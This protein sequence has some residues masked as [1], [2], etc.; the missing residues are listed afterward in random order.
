MTTFTPSA[1]KKAGET[2]DQAAKEMYKDAHQVIV[3]RPLTTRTSSP[4]EA[5]AVAGDALCNV[6]WHKLIA[7]AT[8]GVSSTAGKMRATGSDYSATEEAAAAARFWE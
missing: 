7:S 8:E 2:M 6:P 3:A 4:I 5:A 1:W